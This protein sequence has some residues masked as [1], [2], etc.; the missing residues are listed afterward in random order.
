MQRASSIPLFWMGGFLRADQEET[1]ASCVTWSPLRYGIYLIPFEESDNWTSPNIGNQS[2]ASGESDE[3]CR[4]LI[5]NG[6]ITLCTSEVRQ[7]TRNKDGNFIIWL[8]T[9]FLVHLNRWKFKVINKIKCNKLDWCGLWWKI[10]FENSFL[11]HY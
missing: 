5:R 1:R 2:R 7:Y 8:K 9:Y 6:E 11:C 4:V 10:I 3:A